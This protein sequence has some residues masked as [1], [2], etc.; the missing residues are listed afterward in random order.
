MSDLV[1]VVKSFCPGTE[2]VN[3]STII[4]WFMMKVPQAHVLGQFLFD[5]YPTLTETR[6]GKTWNLDVYGATGAMHALITTL[7]VQNFAPL[8]SPEFNT[9]VTTWMSKD[10]LAF[11]PNQWHNCNQFCHHTCAT[12][13]RHVEFLHYLLKKSIELK[14]ENLHPHIARLCVLYRLPTLLEEM[15]KLSFT[16]SADQAKALFFSPKPRSVKTFVFRHAPPEF[17]QQLKRVLHNEKETLSLKNGAILTSSE[18]FMHVSDFTAGLNVDEFTEI[19]SDLGI[20]PFS[21]SDFI[22]ACDANNYPLVKHMTDSS[23][24]TF[25]RKR[26]HLT[27]VLYALSSRDVT[28]AWNDVF[29]YVIKITDKAKVK[30]HAEDAI[31]LMTRSFY[32]DKKPVLSMFTNWE[33]PP[34]FTGGCPLLTNYELLKELDD[35]KKLTLWASKPRKSRI[36]VHI[37]QNVDAKCLFVLKKY[38]LFGQ[39]YH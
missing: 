30:I 13:L 37:S 1:A 22:S 21:L 10:F 24:P 23:F 25:I 31:Y 20:L 32:L 35:N 39:F 3:L 16:F 33:R 27:E 8:T 28:P 6:D 15:D 29:R 36:D 17:K 34:K 4:W 9:V 7:N 11:L 26:C 14:K 2:K 18:I 38:D 19:R 5:T 12:R